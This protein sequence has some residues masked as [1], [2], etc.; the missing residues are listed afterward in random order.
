MKKNLAILMVI[1]L[2]C[3]V[4]AAC[5]SDGGSTQIPADSPYIGTWEAARATVK[6]EETSAEDVLG[7]M[8][9]FT[10]KADG[11]ADVTSEDGTSSGTWKITGDGVAIRMQDAKAD[12]KFTSEGSALVMKVLGCKIYFEKK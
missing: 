9:L 6:D 11:T 7:D 8:F 10:L 12:L 2:L 3:S 5:G 4:F 1:L